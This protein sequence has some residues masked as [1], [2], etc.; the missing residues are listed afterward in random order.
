MKKS[1]SLFAAVLGVLSLAPI[2]A[3]AQNAQGVLITI[4]GLI[5]TVI[6]ILI[7]AAIAYFIYT[8]VKYIMGKGDSGAIVN[9]LIGLF[10]IV[11][12]WGIIR[13]VQNTFGLDNNNQIQT[14][15]LPC[16]QGVNC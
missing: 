10:V 14:Q 15:D 5:N 9:G 16:V 1:F 2:A 6:T 13:I 3:F 11:A 7:I 4:L 12:F 8:V